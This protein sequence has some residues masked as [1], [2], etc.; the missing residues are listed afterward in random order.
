MGT[1]DIE[2][3]ESVLVFRR[4]C[5]G[6]LDDCVS[7]PDVV[8]YKNSGKVDYCRDTEELLGDKQFELSYWSIH[9]Y[10]HFY[11][12]ILEIVYNTNKGEELI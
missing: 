6:T 9:R 5:L 4:M 1:Y 12:A 2:N 7:R 10:D 8:Y 11:D 3:N